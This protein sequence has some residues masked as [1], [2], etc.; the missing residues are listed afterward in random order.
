MA[1]RKFAL[2]KEPHAAE[3]GDTQLLFQPEVM[4]DEFMDAYAALRDAQ[5]AAGI[6]VGNLDNVDP[7]T[8]RHVSRAL[9]DFLAKVMLPESAQ[10]MTQVDVVNAGTVLG[11][12]RTWEEAEEHAAKVQGARATNSLRL[13]DRVIVELME[14]VVELY[15]GGA[16]RRPP[17]S[18]SGSA[19]ASP[20]T[21]RRGTGASPSKG[22]TRTNGLS[23]G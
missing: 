22:S 19:K 16:D 10:L 18:S 2:N 7:N 3:I 12:Y 6:D 20:R 23:A 9:R 8:M 13:P 15:G 11:S 1:T 21:G 5:D 4:G 14:W 17:T